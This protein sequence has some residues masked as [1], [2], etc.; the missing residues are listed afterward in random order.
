M[1]QELTESEMSSKY[2][3]VSTDGGVRDTVSVSSWHLHV[4]NSSTVLPWLCKALIREI[5][6]Q[7]HRMLIFVAF[8]PPQNL[9]RKAAPVLGIYETLQAEQA[10]GCRSLVG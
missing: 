9:R 8:A 1:S 5:E 4:M 6:S 3:I 2:L 10:R 7:L